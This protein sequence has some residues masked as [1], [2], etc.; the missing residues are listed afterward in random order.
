GGLVEDA[1]TL[2][3]QPVLAPHGS[4]PVLAPH[5]IDVA[6]LHALGR[7]PVGPLPAE[8]RAEDRA[9]GPQPVVEGRDDERPA[10]LVFLVREA[11]GIVLAIGLER[12]GAGPVAVP[13]QPG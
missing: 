2:A 7:E 3:H 10:A 13:V 12:A 6:G 4:E 5:G 8:L 11:D 9:A 1:D